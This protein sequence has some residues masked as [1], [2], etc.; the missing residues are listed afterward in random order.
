MVHFQNQVG[1][2]WGTLPIEKRAI[3]TLHPKYNSIS[4]L[5]QKFRVSFYFL[6]PSQIYFQSGIIEHRHS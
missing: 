2:L 6:Y 4:V 3:F 5:F 1:N